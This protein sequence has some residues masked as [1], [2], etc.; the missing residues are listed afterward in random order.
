MRL[1][2]SAVL[3]CGVGLLPLSATVIGQPVPQATISVGG[4]TVSNGGLTFSYDPT[5]DM[6]SISGNLSGSGWQVS[7]SVTT[8]PD[9]FVLYSLTTDNTTGAPLPF[10][11]TLIT[12]VLLGP[13]DSLSNQF[14]GTMTDL[15]GNG[16]S[17]TGIMQLALLDNNGVPAVQLGTFSCV[18]GASTPFSVYN[19]PSGPGFGP[20]SAQ[21]ANQTYTSLGAHLAFT[22]S[23]NAADSFSGRVD[24]GTVPEPAIPLL[25]GSG[26]V[27]LALVR[28][29]RSPR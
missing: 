18:H 9:P 4:N 7:L 3:T 23:P 24:L 6:G 27:S 17:L 13:Y 15:T 21:V 26:L 5:T 16:V 11:F 12:P 19:C 25:L 8:Q 28:R 22:L 14:N 20:L 1:F 29:R 2:V 10:S